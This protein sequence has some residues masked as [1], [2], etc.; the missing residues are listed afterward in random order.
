MSINIMNVNV[1][2][3]ECNMTAGAYSNGKSAHTIHEFSPSVPPRYKRSER[4]A[5]IIYLPIIARSITDLTI[6]IVDQ[7]DCSIFEEK[8]S[9]LDCTYDGDSDNLSVRCSC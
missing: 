3:V 5:Q 9:P 8:R 1:I 6:R 2:R 4:S 7:N